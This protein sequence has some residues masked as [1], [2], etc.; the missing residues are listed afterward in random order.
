MRAATAERSRRRRRLIST[1][2]TDKRVTMRWFLNW[3]WHA[4]DQE[5]R[6]SLMMLTGTCDDA[7][8]DLYCDYLPV[9]ARPGDVAAAWP[10]SPSI[11]TQAN[12]GCSLL[13]LR[14]ASGVAGSPRTR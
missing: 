3:Y 6:G 1:N 5:I 9:R 7:L 4:Y 11:R 2:I 8:T 10:P 14:S 13:R 12:Q